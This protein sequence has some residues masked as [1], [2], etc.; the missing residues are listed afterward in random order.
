MPAAL[1][2]AAV[3]LAPPGGDL[4][5]DGPPE[6]AR[7]PPTVYEI[8]LGGETIEAREGEPVTLA[9][10]FDGPTLT[11]APKPTRTLDVRGVRFEFP[12]RFVFEA[13]LSDPSVAIWTLEGS[14]AT[15]MLYAFP[16]PVSAAEI[17]AGMVEQT[18][19]TP[20]G[21]ALLT[22]PGGTLTGLGFDWTL[23][24]Q[25]V[26]TEAFDLPAPAGQSRV[27]ILQDVPPEDAD[28]SAE[29]AAVG[30]LLRKTLR[31]AN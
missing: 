15:I 6:E 1:L 31:T 26:R 24:E 17:A 10:R 18:G 11:V 28:R 21:R 27:L 30:Q 12:R 4:P 22:V 9:G 20:R 8:T 29:R 25:R 23:A 14:D 2:L 7:E 16:T 13:D 3:V 19:P 5:G